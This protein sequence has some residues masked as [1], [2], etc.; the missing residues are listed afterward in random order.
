VHTEAHEV[1]GW[2]V[3]QH[4]MPA[5]SK[6]VTVSTRVIER[7]KAP[8]ITLTVRGRGIVTGDD[9][10]VYPDRV[11][12]LFSPERGN[13]PKG[14]VTTLADTELEFWCFNW[15]ANRGALP[16]VEALRIVEDQ[17]VTLPQDRRVLVC[18]GE[19]GGHFAAESFIADG[20]PMRAIAPTYGFLIGGLRA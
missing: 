8:N 18:V 7:A 13:V 6:L 11:P 3:H 14:S 19:I 10:T 1:F 4:I 12:G 17:D 5:G 9:G 15:T 16:Q 20:L 2:K